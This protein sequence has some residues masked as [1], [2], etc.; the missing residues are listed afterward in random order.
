M[1]PHKLIGQVAGDSYFLILST[2]LFTLE[3][4]KTSYNPK[5]FQPHGLWELGKTKK[6]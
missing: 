6:Q 1:I 2:I 4:N 3:Q 5:N